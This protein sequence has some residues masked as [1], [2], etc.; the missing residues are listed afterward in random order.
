MTT[1]TKFGKVADDDD[2]DNQNNNKKGGDDTV[3]VSWLSESSELWESGGESKREGKRGG[4]GT[5]MSRQQNSDVQSLTSVSKRKRRQPKSKSKSSRY[6]WVCFFSVNGEDPLCLPHPDPPPRRVVVLP[7]EDEG[8]VRFP[9]LDGVER[10][11]VEDGVD[12]VEF[13]DGEGVEK[14]VGGVGD[15]V[16][17]VGRWDRGF[18]LDAVFGGALGGV[19]CAVE[20]VRDVRAARKGGGTK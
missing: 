3:K 13:L 10:V 4:G 12:D 7:S 9:Q 17:E 1:K 20:E 8:L 16:F 11:G 6:S 5:T 14:V 19:C 2:E 18:V 15:V